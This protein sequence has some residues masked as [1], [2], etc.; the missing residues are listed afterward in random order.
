M[1]KVLSGSIPEARDMEVQIERPDGSRVTVIVNIRPLK[2]DREEITGAINCFVDINER[3]Q[4]QEAL[5][6]RTEQFETLLNKSP[7]GV[8]LVDADFRI[9]LMNPIAMLVFGEIPDLIGRD[10]DKAIHILWPKPSAD[11]IVRRF[12]HTLEIGETYSIPEFIEKRLERGVLEYYAWQIDRIRLPDGR[13]GVVC[14]FRDI[15]KSV[16]AREALRESDDRYRAATAAMSDVIWT[17]NSDGLMDGEQR[18]WEQF[19]GQSREEYQGYGWSKA[20]HP[21]DAQPTIEALSRAVAEKRM[22]VYEHRVRRRDG[23]WRVCSIRAVPVLNADQTIREWVGVHTDITERKQDEAK[24][25]QLAAEMSEADRRKDEFIATLAHELRNPLAPIRNGLQVIKLAG[26]NDTVEQARTMMERQLTQMVR[27][28]DD[29]LDVNRISRG[30]I[31][32]RTERV[33]IRAVIDAAV[34]TSRPLIEEAGHDLVVAMPDERIFV[35]GDATRLAQVVSNLLSNSAKYMHR[36]GHIRLTVRRDSEGVAVSVADEG[37]GIPPAMLDMVFVMFTQVDRTLEKTSGGL[38][39]G[40]SLVKG[41]VEMHGGT[42]EARSDGEGKGSEFVVQLPVA[43]EASKPPEVDIEESKTVKSSLRILVVDDNRDGANS[44][45]MMLKIMGNDTRTAYD[46]QAGVDVAGEF[47]P[48]VILLDIGLPK[49]NGHEASRYIRE[50]SWGKG[51]VLIAVTGWGQDEDRRR[52]Q[53]AGFDHHM[54]KPVDPKV[55]MKMIAGIQVT[56]Q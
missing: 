46:G 36:G 7:L 2:N 47:R 26:A 31:E 19:T 18:G 5:R 12:R 42:I 21:E 35:D 40:L 4:T 37:I 48:D 39:I 30:K 50:Q 29:L 11:E 14:Y 38:G 23:K 33:E 13:Y 41:L 51:V 1:A 53:E 54:V 45:A 43:I 56:K 6:R 22:F 55:L 34:E 16:I 49:L 20:V 15:S 52:S 28:L 32:L 27:L 25:R 44:L 10:F 17:N 9:Q 24:L 8:Y 3:K